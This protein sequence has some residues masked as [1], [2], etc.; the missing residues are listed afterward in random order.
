MFLPLKYNFLDLEILQSFALQLKI[1]H[2]FLTSVVALD[3]EINLLTC[4]SSNIICA[5]N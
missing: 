5:S 2:L 1:N 4:H 3:F